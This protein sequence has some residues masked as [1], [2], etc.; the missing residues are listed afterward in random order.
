MIKILKLA[1]LT[2]SLGLF[3]ACAVMSP[4][5]TVQEGN[6]VLKPEAGKALL[7][8]LRP[9]SYGGAV[10]ATIY[11]GAAYIGTISAN[12]KI[13]YQADPGKHMFMVIGESADFMQADLVA[14]KTYYARVSARMGIWKARFSFEPENGGTSAE[15]LNAWLKE[16][17]LARINDQGRKWAMENKASIMQK[18]DE[19]LPVWNNKEKS[20]QQTLLSGSGK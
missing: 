3:S 17:R 16:T 13:A 8:F 11:D 14:G 19:Y 20:S 10:Q 4:H 18:H 2:L 1:L 9:S 7:V 6:P 15:E 5:M 12:T